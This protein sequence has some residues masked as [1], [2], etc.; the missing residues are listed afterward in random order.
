MTGETNLPREF[1][2][3]VQGS[4]MQ[5]RIG[6]ESEDSRRKFFSAVRE[7]S[8]AG[9]WEALAEKFGRRRNHFQLYQY[10]KRLLPKELFNKMLALLP[11]EKQG[12]FCNKTF[13]KPAN[14]GWVKGGLVNNQKNREKLLIHLQNC[15][16]KRAIPKETETEDF[17]HVLLLSPQLC[18]FIGAFIGD[19]SIDR[20]LD[21]GRSHY[22]VQITGD[23]VLDKGYLLSHLAQI[24]RGLF[25]ANPKGYFR[26]NDNGLNL[27]VY[28]KKLFVLLTRRFGFPIGEKTFTVKIP[29]EIMNSEEKLIFA[30]VRGIFDTDGCV[31]IDRRK[32]YKKPYGRIVLHTV[33]EQLHLQVKEIL[34]QHFSLYTAVKKEKPLFHQAKMYEIVVYGNKQIEKW[35]QLIGFSNE[36][37]LSKIRKLFGEPLVGFEPTT[38]S[39][40]N[41]SSTRLSYKGLNS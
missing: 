34:L 18:E 9:S 4:V 29:E 19:G 33:S 1:K 13:A 21:N 38:T 37:H 16:G 40:Q 10:S 31:F 14:W 26:K 2:S 24:A 27:D 8:G 5:G 11:K 41:S 3:E 30:T 23:N 36:R 7:A 15:R 25:C 39:L 6:F 17:C 28:S 22:H 35:M 32:A 12:F 20:H